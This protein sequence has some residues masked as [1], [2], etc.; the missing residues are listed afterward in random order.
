MFP[1]GGIINK[2]QMRRTNILNIALFFLLTGLFFLPFNSWEGL[3]FL[4]EFYRDSG[5]LFFSGAGF[6]ILFKKKINIPYKNIIFQ[7]LILFIIWAFLATII[8]S[9]EATEY[10][11]KQSS[12]L[13]RFINQYGALIICSII[14]PIHFLMFFVL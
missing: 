5:F 12:G 13:E 10:Y 6:F 4:G 14:L 8:N 1:R 11:F 3:P 9:A 7:L 2:N